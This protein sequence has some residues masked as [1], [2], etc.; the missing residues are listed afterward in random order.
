MA[1]KILIVE[2][3]LVVAEDIRLTIEQAA[4]E[5]CG[6]APSVNRALELVKQQKPI[7][8]AIIPLKRRP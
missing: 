2:D 1:E 5:F 6:I 7:N 3:E 4:H 8:F